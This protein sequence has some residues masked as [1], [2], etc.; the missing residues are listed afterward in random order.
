[1]KSSVAMRAAALSV[2]GVCVWCVSSGTAGGCACWSVILPNGPQVSLHLSSPWLLSLPF[3]CPSISEAAAA[4]TVHWVSVKIK[5]AFFLWGLTL[6]C[7]HWATQSFFFQEKAARFCCAPC[8]K[9]KLPLSCLL[10]GAGVC[11]LERETSKWS[12]QGSEHSNNEPKWK[13]GE[14]KRKGGYGEE[15]V[16]FSQRKLRYNQ[17]KSTSPPLTHMCQSGSKDKGLFKIPWKAS[18]SPLT[19]TRINS[20]GSQMLGCCPTVP[21][22]CHCFLCLCVERERG[23]ERNWENRIE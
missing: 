23:R 11:G 14:W 17:G 4:F 19:Y 18:L 8:F 6:N 20:P 13:R 22:S 16:L 5:F 7:W 9:F 12:P 10:L 1:M 2:S 3:L 15:T 21:A